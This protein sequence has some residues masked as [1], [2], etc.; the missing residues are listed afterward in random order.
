[1][2]LLGDYLLFGLGGE[3]GPLLFGGASVAQA[4]SN[5]GGATRHSQPYRPRPRF[6]EEELEEEVSNDDED[7]AAA[8]VCMISAWRPL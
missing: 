3:Q 7:V 2:D 8:L 1:M 5:I 4:S 6:D